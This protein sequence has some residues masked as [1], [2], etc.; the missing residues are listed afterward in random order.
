[1]NLSFPIA[2]VILSIFSVYFFLRG[3]GRFKIG[4]TVCLAAVLLMLIFNYSSFTILNG[5]LT[6]YPIVLIILTLGIYA[7]MYEVQP[8]RKLINFFLAL[9]VGVAFFAVDELL[10]I[11]FYS[12]GTGEVIGLMMLAGLF[13]ALIAKTNWEVFA[14]TTLSFFFSTVLIAFVDAVS[15]VNISWGSNDFLDNFIL[16]L[17]FALLAHIFLRK[18]KIK[19]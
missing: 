15:Y 1:M 17:S 4:T 8:K 9:I 6:I 10:L 7:L 11:A 2:P 19:A 5:T 12:L 14:I 3:E 18:I 16:I 13:I